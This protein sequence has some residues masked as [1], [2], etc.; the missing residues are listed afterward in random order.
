M[1]QVWDTLAAARDL[2]KRGFLDAII[3]PFYDAAK[4]PEYWNGFAFTQGRLP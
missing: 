1:T 4:L 3:T 2:T